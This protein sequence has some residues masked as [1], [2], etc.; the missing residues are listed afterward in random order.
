VP[1]L[2]LSKHLTYSVRNKREKTSKQT[3]TTTIEIILTINNNNNNKTP[4]SKS[5]YIYKWA[6]KSRGFFAG[7]LRD[8][9]SSNQVP[10]LIPSFQF[11]NLFCSPP[12]AVKNWGFKF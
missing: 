4:F 12:S 5:I 1:S 2:H 6:Y 10:T 9:Q 7:T 11:Q 8:I 3:I